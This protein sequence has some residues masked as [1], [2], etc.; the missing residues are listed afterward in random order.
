MQDFEKLGVFYLGRE[1][2]LGSKALKENLLLYDARDLVTHA[3][4]V[5]MTG[6]G[7]TGLCIGLIEEAAIDG[8]PSI[9]IDPKGDLA[10]LLLTFPNLSSSEFQPWVN[11]EDAARKGLSVEEYAAQQAAMWQK[12]LADWGQ[13]P[14][15]IQRLR[16]SAEFVVYTPGSSAGV[17]VSILKSFA[18]P[19]PEILEDGEL[20]Q[21]RINTTVTSLLGLLNITADPLQSREHILLSTIVGQMWR[22]GQDLDLA[23]LIAQIQNPPVSK[24][25]VLD[26]ESFYPTKD[27][28]S[29]VMSLNNLLASPGF[30]AWL[31]G[32]PLDIGQILYTPQGK[33]RVAIFSVAHLGDPERMFFVSMLL[34]QILGW[35]RTQP[36][37][38]SLRALVYMDEIFGYFPPV[39]NP[40]SKQPLLTMLKQARAYGVGLVLAT[41]NPVDLDYKGLSNTGTWFLGRLQTERDKARVMD[42]LEGAAVSTGSTFD[43]QKMEQLLAGLGSRVFLMNN[44]H[45]DEPVV[46]T[47][48]WCMSYLR[49]PLTR[50]QIKQLMDPYKA[51]LGILPAAQPLSKPPAASQVVSP[52]VPTAAAAFTAP[53]AAAAQQM[54]MTPGLQP[55]LPPDVPQF[56]VPP[57]G[58]GDLTYRPVLVG[59][60]KVRFYDSKLKIDESQ[61]AIYQTAVVDEAVPVNWEDAQEAGFTLNDLERN[62]ERGARFADLPPSAAKARNYTSWSRDFATWVFGNQKL[63]LLRSPSTGKVSK[64]G[65][66]ERDFRVRLQLAAR[67]QRDD[68]VDALKKKYTTKTAALQERIRKA[69]QVV[70]READQASQAKM[71][72]AISFGAT[73]LGAVLGRKSGIKGTVG[74]ATTA[75]RGIGRSAQQQSDVARAKETV[76]TY[77]QQLEDLNREFEAEAEALANKIDP[78]SEELDT[79]TIRPKK[80]DI[81]VQLVALVW[82]PH[83]DGEPTW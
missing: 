12:G 63:D 9:L 42:G 70:E 24:I 40:P 50:S 3:V 35:M 80:T 65:E 19:P 75:A 32:T 36:G 38:T 62:P 26:I 33:P 48:R 47:T 76:E 16:S 44:T 34:N 52:V 17:P 31:E 57:R 18:A 64:A 29:L 20:F 37:T 2:D 39:A 58:G 83:R 49:G 73:L 30:S 55:T 6:S 54:G 61:D 71:Q 53:P 69:Q 67:E 11:A 68:A 56:F 4:V 81:S 14:E 21:E 60:A 77:Q 8:V 5:G 23:A 45:E 66:D 22:Q 13:T 7:K 41:Q 79:I 82:A 25:G 15:R 1:Y 43:R 59:A 46:F 10:N 28:F 72:T 78:M 74:K 27:R 51:G